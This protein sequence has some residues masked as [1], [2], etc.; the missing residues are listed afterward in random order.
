MFGRGHIPLALLLLAQAAAAADQQ[1]P[2]AAV[3]PQEAER[4]FNAYVRVTESGIDG[5]LREKDG[6][7]WADTPEKRITLRQAGVVCEP[8]TGKG[9]RRVPGGLIH[10]WVGAAFIPGATVDEVLALLQDY[11]HHNVT[12]APEVIASRTLA[13]NGNDFQVRLRLLKRK[14]VTVVLDTEYQVHYRPLEGHDW[15][16]TSYSTRIEEIANAGG[17]REHAVPSHG[18]MWRLN[19]YWLIRQRDGGVYVEC[20]A[21]S[22]SRGVP[23]AFAWVVVPIIRS[24]P[25]DALEHTLRATRAGM[26][27]RIAA[28][29]QPAARP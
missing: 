26:L 16:S 2:T 28:R 15:R 19:S 13:R 4:A 22:L 11:D 18:Y 24:L 25:R 20:E 23:A 29:R 14:L 9:E 3:P 7:L 27:D 5:R 6:F 17:P 1:A 12:Y 10:D 8:R 21:V